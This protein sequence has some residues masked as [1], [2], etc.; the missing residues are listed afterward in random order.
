[1]FKKYEL[2]KL[3][4]VH[5]TFLGLWYNDSFSI[6][7]HLLQ[8]QLVGHVSNLTVEISLLKFDYRPGTFPSPMYLT[9]FIAIQVLKDVGLVVIIVRVTNITPGN[10]DPTDGGVFARVRFV[11]YAFSPGTE[12]DELKAVATIDPLID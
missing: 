10:F 9:K 2:E 7:R 3:L 6:S 8:A 1:M 4:Y 12:S 11:C 5:P